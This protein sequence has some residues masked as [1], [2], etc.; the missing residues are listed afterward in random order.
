MRRFTYNAS[1]AEYHLMAKFGS[2]PLPTSSSSGCAFSGGKCAV[3]SNY[4]AICSSFFSLRLAVRPFQLLVSARGKCNQSRPASNPQP[5][6]AEFSGG[7]F[8]AHGYCGAVIIALRVLL[9]QCA[10][11]QINALSPRR[12][13]TPRWAK[14]GRTVALLH[15][16]SLHPLPDAE[17]AQ[18][19]GTIDCSEA[20]E[21]VRLFH[22]RAR[23]CCVG[24]RRADSSFFAAFAYLQ[25]PC[26]KIL[27]C[28]VTRSGR[29]LWRGARRAKP[30]VG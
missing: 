3:R 2:S 14:G 11:A 26:W 25:T 21:K 12:G 16:D 23:P 1:S 7:P 20:S 22:S 17:A 4:P 19:S 15:A 30:M 29:R 18:A 24:K 6:G 5:L 28:P 10:A 9:V 8:M 27:V 13:A